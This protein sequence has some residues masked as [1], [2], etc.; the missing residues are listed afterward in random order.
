[1]SS[2]GLVIG[3]TVVSLKTGNETFYNNVFIPAVK[4]CPPEESHK[5]ALLAFKWKL[6]GENKAVEP[7]NLVNCR[8]TLS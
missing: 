6:F 7:T 3:G 4:F 5:L 2:V 8:A 1:M